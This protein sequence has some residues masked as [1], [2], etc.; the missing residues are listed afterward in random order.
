MAAEPDEQALYGAIAERLRPARPAIER[1]SAARL[2]VLGRIRDSVAAHREYLTV[3]R[4]DGVTQ[5][6]ADGAS[7]RVLREDDLMRVGIVHLADGAQLPWLPGAITQELLVLGGALAED[8]ESPVMR[9]RHAYCVRPLADDAAV[10]RASG[11]TTVYLRE[12][13]A[14]PAQLPTLEARWWAL[15]TQPMRWVEPGHRR[16][17]QSAAGVEVLPLRGDSEVV[18]MLVRFEPGASV[19]DHRHALNEDCLVLEGEM[20]LGDI[21]LRCGDYQLAP[22]GGS[23]FGETSDV[24][25]VFFFHGALDPVLRSAPAGRA[26]TAR[27]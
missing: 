8:G 20:F 10:L 13:L 3:R 19:A 14:E 11:D 9:G 22:A 26:V 25:V 6:C 16:W 18:S 5:P 7:H 4:E 21:L 12:C 17:V 27:P 15:A 2:G 24:G 1:E 23:H